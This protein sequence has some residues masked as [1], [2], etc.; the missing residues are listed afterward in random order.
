MNMNGIS[1]SKKNEFVPVKSTSNKVQF[2]RNWGLNILTLGIYGTVKAFP[3]L[4]QI[5][6]M[7]LTNVYLQ[8]QARKLTGR[9]KTLENRL[10]V[11]MKK[12]DDPASEK[13][14]NV[15]PEL[16]KIA[17]DSNLA[18][19]DIIMTEVP[20]ISSPKMSK[21]VSNVALG[22]ISSIGF[23]IA[24]IL[25]VGVFGA[26]QNY[27]LKKRLIALYATNEMIQR[28]FEE[29]KANKL[30]HFEHL[31]DTMLDDIQLKKT[32]KI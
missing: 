26:C 25:T 20:Y 16:K 5:K 9:W 7:N 18:S 22:I 30:Q 29:N 32:L 12:I 31:I 3:H 14:N 27:A 24:N 6:K 10:N 11:V 23:I 2:L 4:H 28:E 1:P 13:D 17:Y 19:Y 21:Q 15:V 8:H